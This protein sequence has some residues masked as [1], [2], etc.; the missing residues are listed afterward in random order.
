MNPERSGLMKKTIGT[1]AKIKRPVRGRDKWLFP[2]YTLSVYYFDDEIVREVVIKP[3]AE[4]QID[5]PS[6]R[7]SLGDEMYLPR[8][9]EHHFGELK[10]QAEHQR[11][12]REKGERARWEEDKKQRFVL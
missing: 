10:A 11:A 1:S 9:W 12:E 5:I 7:Q 6:T 2:G 3:K 8:D 4:E